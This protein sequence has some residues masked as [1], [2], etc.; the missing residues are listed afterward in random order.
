MD[1]FQ[2]VEKENQMSTNIFMNWRLQLKLFY[3]FLTDLPS[4]C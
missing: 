4:I 1:D 2:N 3:W